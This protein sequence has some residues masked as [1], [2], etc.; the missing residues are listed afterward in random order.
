MVNNAIDQPEIFDVIE[1]IAI[2]EAVS[3]E[4][5]EFNFAIRKLFLMLPHHLTDGEV[6]IDQGDGE[7]R[8]IFRSTNERSL[9][10]KLGRHDIVVVVLPNKIYGVESLDKVIDEFERMSSL[11]TRACLF[12]RNSVDNSF[13]D[14]MQK[15]CGCR[16]I[17]WRF[18]YSGV[19]Y[20]SGLIFSSGWNP[21]I[22]THVAKV[23]E[24]YLCEL[25]PALNQNISLLF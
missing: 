3:F 18:K 4:D 1:L 5:L 19:L 23:I 11:N 9:C 7:K 22:S 17:E 20:R 21:S 8:L 24:N 10:S 12:Y 16:G 14:S 25:S 6:F 13:I 15:N 2:S